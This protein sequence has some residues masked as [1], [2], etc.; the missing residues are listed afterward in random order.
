[1]VKKISLFLLLMGCMLN[2]SLAESPF[3]KVHKAGKNYKFEIPDALLG[4]PVLFGSRVVDISTPSAKVYSAGQMRRPPVL[5]RF[6]R[7]DNLIVIEHLDNFVDV[8]PHDPIYEPLSQNMIVGATDYFEI[9]SR[10]DTDNGSLI[11]VTRYFSDE[12]QLAWPLPDNVRKGRLDSKLTHLLF[13][14]EHDDRIN[15]RTYYEFSGG[16]DPFAITVQ[17]FL[18]Q[19]PEE[20][21]L[22]RYNDERIG[23]QSVNKRAYASGQGIVTN[24]YI[25]RWRIEPAAEDRDRHA[26]GELVKPVQP[27]IMYIEP[28]F[29]AAWVPYIKEGIEVWNRAFETIGFKNVMQAREFPENDP[30]FDPYDI[31]T[32]VIRYIPLNE[33]NA[34]GQ[35]WTDPRSGEI[36][37]GEVLWWNDVVNLLN[38]WRFTQTA[39]VDPRARALEYDIDITGEMVRYAMA[40]EVGHVLGIQHNLRSSYAFAVDSLRSPSFTQQYG[41]A[42]SIMDYARYNH[43]AQPGD[44]EKGVNLTPPELGPFDVF[45]IQYGYLYVHGAQKPDDEKA[46]LDS[47]FATSAAELNYDFA[48]FIAVPISPDPS[49]QPQSLGNDV[50]RS[51]GYGIANT[52]VILNNLVDWTLEEGGDMA[53]INRRYDALLRQYFRF[54]NLSMSYVGGVYTSYGPLPNNLQR[55]VAVDRQKQKETLEFVVRQ[56]KEAPVYLDQPVFTSTIG[57]RKDA[58]IRSQAQQVESFLNR[59]ILPRVLNNHAF[60]GEGYSL[61]EYLSDL[62]RLIWDTFGTES[63]YDRNVRITYVRLLY[64][65]TVTDEISGSFQAQE[66]LIAEAASSQLQQTKQYLERQSRRRKNP[67]RHHYT[68][69]LS[70]IQNTN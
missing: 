56:I 57:S 15:I 37:N 14:R 23:Y 28:Y 65:L 51:S 44:L 67:A 16:K 29:P 52:R 43:V 17:Y 13:M 27:I 66:M 41:T 5:I 25:S 54:I 11:D 24:R 58:V 32:N 1:M 40:H 12:V 48:P 35:T 53:L 4:K 6:A 36:I 10:N 8:D 7:R 63:L 31:K 46:A 21:L 70:I 64:E 34:A 18:L 9:A 47:L 50:V 55:H 19:L 22:T 62:D 20:P 42:A 39:A 60:E 38:M 68:F 45:S 2:I 30:D 69:L 59:F 26:R 3:I 33:A 61:E 49:A